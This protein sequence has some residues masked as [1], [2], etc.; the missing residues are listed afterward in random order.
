MPTTTGAA[1]LFAL[2]LDG[3]LGTPKWVLI[4][5]LNPGGVS[6]G[7]GGQYFVGDFDGTTFTSETTVTPEASLRDNLR[8]YNWLDWGRDYYAAVSFSGVPDGKRIMIA[9][10]NNWDYGNHIPTSPWRSAMTL[11]REVRLETVHGEPRLLQVP[12]LPPAYDASPVAY[13]LRH[14]D[15]TSAVELLPAAAWGQVLRIDVELFPGSAEDIG[16]IV[17]AGGAESTRI[18]YDRASRCLRIDR[19]R[20]GQVNFHPSFASVESAP[21]DLVNGTVRLAVYV[22]RSSVEVFAQDGLVTMTDQ[23][24]PDPASIQVALYAMGGAGSIRSLTIRKLTG[25]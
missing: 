25:P 17:R 23:I 22:D 14:K 6:G 21:V 19:T 15:V 11:P 20:S 3:D 10:M 18:G 24:F 2:P 4:V 12:V 1:D 8:E 9:W 16:L 7:S 5:N 13:A